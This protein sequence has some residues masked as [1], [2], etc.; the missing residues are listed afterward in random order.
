MLGRMVYLK[1]LRQPECFLGLERF[2]KGCDIMSIKVV[3]HKN[4]TLDVW[5]PLVKQPLDALCPVFPCP[6]LFCHSVAPSGKRLCKQKDATGAVS[7]VLVIL[8]S[9]AS[10]VGSKTLSC[11]GKKL[12]GFLIHA[13]HWKVFVVRPAVYFKNIFH[14]GHESCTMGG[15]YTPTLLQMRLILVFFRMRPT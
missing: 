13:N 7:Y 4:N 6:L 1:T 15:W 2:I 3:T 12:N 10:A 8:I 5:I 14:R 11:L 9:Y